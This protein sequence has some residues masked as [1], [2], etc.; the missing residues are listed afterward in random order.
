MGRQLMSQSISKAHYN[1]HLT[2]PVPRCVRVLCAVRKKAEIAWGG[3]CWNW[4]FGKCTLCWNVLAS[5]SHRR[6][7]NSIYV[8]E[9]ESKTGFRKQ[10]THI[11]GLY[12]HYAK[13][14]LLKTFSVS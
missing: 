6:A 4:H 10:L 11:K 5:S 3:M 14:F 2:F 12:N 1:K 7:I 13:V 9:T 8:H